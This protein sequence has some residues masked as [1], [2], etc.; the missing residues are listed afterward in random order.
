MLPWARSK[1][2]FVHTWLAARV[3]ALAAATEAPP[4]IEGLGRSLAA[5]EDATG[6][7]LRPLAGSAEIAQ[8]VRFIF[9]RV[10]ATNSSS[11]KASDLVRT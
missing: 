8:I 7:T 3:S 10:E 4:G 11:K 2:D 9:L 1:P 5:E 6:R